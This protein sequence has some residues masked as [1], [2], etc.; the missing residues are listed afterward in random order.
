MIF[1][2]SSLLFLV[3]VSGSPWENHSLLSI[4][5]KKKWFY[6]AFTMLLNAF[7]H[8]SVQ[9]ETQNYKLIYESQFRHFIKW[10]KICVTF[11]TFYEHLWTSTP[12]GHEILKLVLEYCTL[13]ENLHRRRILFHWYCNFNP[14]T[15]LNDIWY[16]GI[17]DVLARTNSFNLLF[18]WKF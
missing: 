5:W 17:P 10:G 18:V 14:P 11:G 6:N 4:N 1:F 16:C 9:I 12:K 3:K 2:P 13:T 15:R 8:F 7:L